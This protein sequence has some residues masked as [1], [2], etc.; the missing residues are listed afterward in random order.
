MSDDIDSKNVIEMKLLENSF[1]HPNK[2]LPILSDHYFKHRE[3]KKSYEALLELS[4][5]EIFNA[6]NGLVF[7]I[8]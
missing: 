8:V 3:F 6:K 4:D 5:K 7:A 1:K 2:I